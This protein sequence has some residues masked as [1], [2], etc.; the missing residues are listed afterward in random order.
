MSHLISFVVENQL[1]KAFFCQVSVG[2][3]CTE[4]T[5]EF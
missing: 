1:N 3:G 2:Y 5:V 4:M